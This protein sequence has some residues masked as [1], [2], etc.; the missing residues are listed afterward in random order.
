MQIRRRANTL[1]LIRTVYDRAIKRGRSVTI[2]RLDIGCGAIP[3]ELDNL[4]TDEERHQLLALLA[5]HRDAEEARLEEI[6]ARALPATLQRATRWYERQG[7]STGLSALAKASRD[8]FSK[9][10]SAMVR[11]GVGRRRQRKPTSMR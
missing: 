10:L 9:L 1:T 6:A 7:K 4:L 11:A 2:G 8:E 3:P 5:S